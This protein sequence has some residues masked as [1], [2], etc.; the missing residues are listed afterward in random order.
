MGGGREGP[1][2]HRFLAL[3]SVMVQMPSATALCTCPCRGVADVARCLEGDVVGAD[4]LQRATSSKHRR[5][6]MPRS[7]G[8]TRGERGQGWA[9]TACGTACERSMIAL[10]KCN[11]G[12]TGRGVHTGARGQP[13]TNTRRA[14]S[15]S[16]LGYR[17]KV[18]RHLGLPGVILIELQ[19]RICALRIQLQLRRF[20]FTSD[21][22]RR[23]SVRC[24]V[25]SCIR[26]GEKVAKGRM[27]QA[28]N[29]SSRP[30]CCGDC[31][32]GGEETQPEPL[33]SEY[34]TTQNRSGQLH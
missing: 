25:R 19:L 3:V 11:A 30:L 15:T 16:T 21:I 22:S 4:R 8:K 12:R 7:P 34:R 32:E 27:E 13:R 33:L 31:G 1:F 17:L 24:A 2:T 9:R 14:A 23:V 6:I 29:P 10:R 26:A 28:M 20:A 5:N 18:V